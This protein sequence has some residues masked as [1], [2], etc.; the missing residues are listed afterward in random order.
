MTTI[1]IQINRPKPNTIGKMVMKLWQ[2]SSVGYHYKTEKGFGEV[3][4][5]IQALIVYY[6]IVAV[7]LITQDSNERG[8]SIQI[9]LFL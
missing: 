8:C 4:G 6:V 7:S 3:L 1:L 9:N 5:G 2:Y